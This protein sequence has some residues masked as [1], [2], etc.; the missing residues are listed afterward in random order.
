MNRRPCASRRRGVTA[1]RRNRLSRLHHA[2]LCNEDLDET[3]LLMMDRAVILAMEAARDNEVPVGAVIYNQDGII[4]EAANNREASGDP[5]GHAEVVA[6][7]RAGRKL[8]RWRLSD[9]SLAVTLEPCPMCAGALVNARLGRVIYGVD[10]PKAGACRT[11]YSIT[12]DSRL[13]HRVRVSGPVQEQQCRQ[14]LRGFFRDRRRNRIL[15]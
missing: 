10:D 4:A 5:S 14:L 6:I 15:P 13:N 9:C 3:D 2:R 11:L 8:D 1:R 7:R 12:D